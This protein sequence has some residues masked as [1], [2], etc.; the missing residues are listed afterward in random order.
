MTAAGDN[1]P[2][3]Y[4]PL[5]GAP[6]AETA[7]YSEGF[8]GRN[9]RPAPPPADDFGDE[10]ATG[11]S[12]AAGSGPVAANPLAHQLAVAQDIA[13]ALRRAARRTT[14]ELQAELA[15]ARRV[16]LAESEARAAAEFARDM[17]AELRAVA[18]SERDQ[19]RT[20]I[21]RMRADIATTTV[22]AV[23]IA[24]DRAARAITGRST[25]E[26]DADLEDQT[27]RYPHSPDALFDDSDAD[28]DT[29]VVDPDQLIGGAP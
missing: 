17:E 19:L 5:S 29:V 3:L 25:A 12:T 28:C 24:L 11:P 6:R 10:P 2:R 18:E 16:L 4:G 1:L 20:E 8:R 22:D 27:G 26:L 23:R 7:V 9:A 13:A 14:A 21:D 15:Q